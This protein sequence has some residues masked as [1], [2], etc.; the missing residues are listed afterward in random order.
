MRKGVKDGYCFDDRYKFR[1]ALFD[2]PNIWIFTNQDL[3]YDLLS[4]QRWRLWTV[5]NDELLLK[6]KNKYCIILVKFVNYLFI[7]TTI[8]RVCTSGYFDPCTIGHIDYFKRAK[9]LAG[10]DGQLIVIVNN[11]HQACLKKGKSFMKENDRV[12]IIRALKYVDEVYLSID[13][14]RTVCKTLSIIPH[15]THF[16]NGGDQFNDRI[17]EK[18][19]C[20]QLGIQLVDGLGEKIASSSWLT[21]LKAIS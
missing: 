14:D 16:V 13:Q 21:G 19:I 15:L 12:E 1:D 9:E 7:M 11:D 3:P 17:P 20:D 18:S 5:Q 2:I 10:L 8:R 6:K 4:R